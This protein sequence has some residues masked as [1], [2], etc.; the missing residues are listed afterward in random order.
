MAPW[1]IEDTSFWLRR[2]QSTRVRIHFGSSWV[3]RGAQFFMAKPLN[4][5]IKFRT[6]FWA[7]ERK[8]N[9][10]IQ[11]LATVA[12]ISNPHPEIPDWKPFEFKLTGG[13]LS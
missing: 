3:D 13:G 2:G 12:N 8:V 10:D 7:Y 5:G 1:T 11:Y 9:A 4:N 6:D